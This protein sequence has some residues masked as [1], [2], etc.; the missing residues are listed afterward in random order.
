VD[1]DVNAHPEQMTDEWTSRRSPPWPTAH[2]A[3]ESQKKEQQL[4]GTD[5]RFHALATVS[6]LIFW[7]AQPDGESRDASFWCAYTGQSVEDGQNLGWL[8]AIHPE[9][10]E[11]ASEIWLRALATKMPFETEYRLRRADGVYHLFLVRG[12]PLLDAQGNVREWV[13]I[14]TDISE[15]KELEKTRQESEA[16][17]RATFEHAP[18]GIANT[19]LEGRWSEVN[20]QLCDMLGY[21]REELLSHT[22]QDVTHPDDLEAS[23]EYY[24]RLLGGECQSYTLE[25]RYLRKDGSPIW[26]NVTISLVRT[27]EGKPHHF[28]GIIEDISERKQL[29][30]ALQ[31]SEAHFRALFEHAPVGIGQTNQRGKWLN[32]NQHFCDMLGYTREELLAR[33]FQEITH[34]DDLE[35]SLYL[36]RQLWAG[37]SPSLAM[38]KRYLRKD[39]SPIWVNVTISLVRSPEGKFRYTVV[40]IEDISQRKQLEEERVR[41]L[42]RE[43]QARAQAEATARRLRAIQTL[44]DTA[45]EHLSLED[46]LHEL[47]DRIREVMAVDAATILLL[48]EDRQFLTVH[49]SRGLEEAVAAQLRIPFG[50]GVSG[51][52]A[53]SQKPLIVDDLS[54]AEVAGPFLRENIY[55]LVG[56]PLLVKERVIG[57][58]HVG[59]VQPHCFTQDDVQL[60]EMVAYRIALAIDHA[61]LFQ[62]EQHARAEAAARAS[63][64]EATIEA[65]TEGVGIYTPQGYG[66]LTNRSGRKI[67]GIDDPDRFRL[68][69][70]RPH[71]E[72]I[73]LLNCR[74]KDGNPYPP[75][76]SPLTRA[77][78]GEVVPDAES[79]DMLIT[80]LDGH[81]RYLSATA[82]PIRDEQGQ[83]AGAVFVYRDVT[84]RRLLERRTHDALGALL[85]MAEALV[86]TASAQ[87]SLFEED[88]RTGMSAVA[89]RLAELTARVVGCEHVAIAA[90]EPETTQL[91]RLAI[92]TSDPEVQRQWWDRRAYAP[93]LSDSSDPTWVERLRAGEVMY[94]TAK[95]S[96]FSEPHP[97]NVPIILIAPMRVGK[98]LVGLLS[99]GHDSAE[100][101]YTSQE[102]ALAGAIAKLTA[103]VIE[104]EHLLRQREEA[105]ANELAIREANRRMEAF[106]GIAS[107]E[108]KTPLTTIRLHLQMAERRLQRVAAQKEAPSPG[109]AHELARLHAQLL[110]TQGQWARLDRLVNDLLDVSRIQAG[111]LHLSLGP[112]DL[113]ALV[114]GVVEEQR[115][116]HPGRLVEWS[117]PCA[118]PLFIWA[119]AGRIS[120]VVQNYLSNAFKY[121]PEDTPIKV[122]ISCEAAQARVWVRDQGPGLTPEQQANLWQRFYRVPG[123]EVQTGSGVGMG[124]GLHICKTII[125][126][127]QGQVGVESVAGQGSTFWFTLP[128]L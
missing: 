74:D 100:H 128:L 101:V 31:A 62:A 113:A 2:A 41:L 127:H 22:F 107:H 112:V 32:V 14:C 60:L 19:T 83:L 123:V 85:E 76:R 37:T 28:I 96:L 44:T 103:L 116:V 55:S 49:A 29:R 78:Q 63:Q 82:A 97:F 119:D 108:L 12:V 11:Q 84:E 27:P 98:Q 122:G 95:N 126:Q 61:R 70:S 52:I 75:E 125:E 118:E 94:T 6:G 40:I 73:A 99:I 79:E 17:F 16:H 54:K 47:L 120:Q 91:I 7:T 92:V 3:L 90:V 42:E 20:Q 104:R 80:A 15:R 46:L 59:T 106:L 18:V 121:S 57:V 38:E 30:E 111:T 86:G 50:K 43:Q 102:I 110:D 36:S 25:K 34:P 33:S 93:R 68:F 115:Q 89:Q 5:E 124:L 26:V 72:R 109:I 69:T 53:A 13:G 71:P 56:V 24:Y 64:L 88:A 65:M 81:E 1:T 23:L 58:I 117:R 45:L 8:A 66:L 35:G 48:S 77:L 21:T 105:H 9:D 10:R 39:G 51:K 67:L 4:Q 114:Q 87:E